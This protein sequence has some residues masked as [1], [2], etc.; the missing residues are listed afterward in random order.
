MGNRATR[1]PFFA[2]SS[3]LALLAGFYV[4][5]GSATVQVKYYHTT[6]DCSS[7][8]PSSVTEVKEGDCITLDTFIKD[9]SDDISH[10]DTVIDETASGS[11]FVTEALGMIANVSTTVSKLDDEA[12]QVQD[13]L[14]KLVSVAEKFAVKIQCDED[15]VM[16]NHYFRLLKKAECDETSKFDIMTGEFF[17]AEKDKLEKC[18]PFEHHSLKFGSFSYACPNAQPWNPPPPPSPKQ[19]PPPP[20]SPASC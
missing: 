5:Y 13:D 20:S 14:T 18:F 1:E 4:C 11:N 19:P 9:L 16:V 15:A 12:K 10:V 7:K 8:I 6:R 3:L 17:Q 2:M